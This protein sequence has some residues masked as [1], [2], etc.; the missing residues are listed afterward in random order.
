MFKRLFS[1][2]LLAVGLI[3]VV[4]ATP[5]SAA[6]ISVPYE[7]QT[8]TVRGVFKD[9]SGN[10]IANALV[11]TE[12]LTYNHWQ[13]T[14]YTDAQGRYEIDVPA[15]PV[16]VHFSDRAISQY[17]PGKPNADEAERYTVV[18]G[19][20][21]VVDERQVPTGT[22]QGRLTDQAGNP[23][24]R[25]SVYVQAR[26]YSYS[27]RTATTDA[28]GRYSI[29]RVPAGEVSLQFVNNPFSVWAPQ[30]HGQ[31]TARWYTLRNNQTL[32]VDESLLPTGTLTGLI[33]DA[34]GNP[35][36]ASIRA[37]EVDGDGDY[38]TSTGADGRFS[39]TVPAGKWRVELN[40]RQWLPGKIDEAAGKIFRVAAGQSVEV[41]E[42][43]R[44][45]GALR[46]KLR[47][48][49]SKVLKYSFALWHDGTKVAVVNGTNVGSHTFENVLPGDYLF[50][51][52]DYYGEY[53]AP[54]T[55]Q[56]EN[57]VPV[58]VRPETTKTLD[59][60]HP[61]QST[62]SG[63]VTLP[64]GEPA[65][66]LFVHADVITDSMVYQRRTVQTG[67]D[68]EWEMTG[69]FPESY[70]IT[71]T[72]SS[73][74]LSQDGGEVTVAAG[75]SASVNSTWHTGGSLIVTAVD[76]DTG[77]PV[78]NYCV[79]VVT[80]FGKFCT[81]GTT[82]TVA[83]LD[84][85]PTLVT[86]SMLESSEYLGKQDVPVTI[87]A[88][89]RATLTI[90]VEIG[91][92]FNVQ[93]VARATGAAAGA[94]VCFYAVLPNAGGTSEL[95][96]VCTNKQGKGTSDALAPGTYQLFVKPGSSAYGA[97]WYTP[98]GGTGDQK[99]ATKITIKAGKIARLDPAQLDP[100]GS[101][102][103]VV[104]GPDG[105]PVE[106]VEVGVTAF[107]IPR[108][109]SYAESTNKEGKYTVWN[110]GPY[111]WPLLFTPTG[112]L[113]R[114]WSGATGNRFKAETV[115]VT[116]RATNTYDTTLSAGVKV[117][118]TVTIR[119][120]GTAWSGGRLKARGVT[121]GDL[122]AVGDVPAQGGTYEFRVIGDGQLSLEWYLADP[123]TKST[124]WYDDNPRVPANGRKQIDLTIG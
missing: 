119:P 80:K 13:R 97:Q 103:G 76:A 3:L 96:S 107:D 100:G 87:A 121:S 57:A 73:D 74:E 92:R 36:R 52:G 23:V 24:A 43:L 20:T 51:Y 8:G 112:D 90:P 9:R 88:D 106:H 50:S 25:A 34:E 77:A 78:S 62:L 118:G 56:I 4:P 85:G 111:E 113:P 108:P 81:Q 29:T 42:S 5:A 7:P 11:Y 124:G 94:D 120:G 38:S 89:G 83:G 1:A 54:G 116:S 71:L 86:L 82:V 41:N 26:P 123:V 17:A 22:V 67:T 72:N 53:F 30:K 101:I 28:D 115:S 93:A 21:T 84:A 61:E 39:L 37:H 63:R 45:T 102:T 68:G 18:P 110:L 66:N 12:S 15:G 49:S 27:G 58:K 98:E 59:V 35:A 109:G 33:T 32:T 75:G 48:G 46:V 14:A 95:P 105:Q 44:P 70:R 79:A 114:Q 16:T 117:T 55:L 10:P 65:P 60:T 122:L 64:T 40:G 2:G 31:A 104:R 69:V 47:T 19:L 91:G 99:Q 6:Q